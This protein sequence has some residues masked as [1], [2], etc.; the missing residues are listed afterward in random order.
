MENTQKKICDRKL[1][2]PIVKENLHENYIYSYILYS[3]VKYMPMINDIMLMC[4]L[5]LKTTLISPV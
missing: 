1:S 4:I 3:N 2:K 5:L